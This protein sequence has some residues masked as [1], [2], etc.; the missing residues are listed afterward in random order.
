MLLGQLPARLTAEEAAWVLNCKPHDVPVL[1]ASQLL[2]PLG[3]PAPNAPKYFATVELLAKVKDRTWLG[4]VTSAIHQHWHTKNT[5]KQGA[6]G[7]PLEL[8][9]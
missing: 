9:D 5:R 3:N 8:E 7:R 6:C 1:I 4:R 2:N